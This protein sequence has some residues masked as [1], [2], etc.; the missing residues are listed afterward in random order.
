MAATAVTADRLLRRSP[1][2]WAFEARRRHQ[3]AAVTCHAVPHRAAFERQIDILASMG[4]FV[5][6]AD[7]LAAVEDGRPLPDHAILLTFDDGDRTVYDVAAPVLA[8]RAIPAVAFVI[9][10]LIGTSEPFWWTEVEQLAGALAVARLKR[11]PDDERRAAIEALRASAAA[12]VDPQPQ[13]RPAEL[14]ALEAQGIAIGSHTM[15]HPML[16]QCRPAA[17]VAEVAGSFGDLAAMLGAPPASFAYPSG[18]YDDVAR[19]AVIDAGYRIAFAFDHR[20][21]PVPPPDQFAVSRLRV[22]A[23]AS[24]DRVRTIVSGLHPAVHHLR[25][26]R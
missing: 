14:T 3:L 12:P 4:Q 23:T 15:T 13:L 2:Q 19:R 21:T 20:L 18:A 10:G 8:D 25:G 11:V 6:L 24:E 16:D 26:R 1:F 7:V 17:V 9:T 5:A 22:A